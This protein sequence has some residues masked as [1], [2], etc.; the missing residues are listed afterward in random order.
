MYF[1]QGTKAQRHD[2]IYVPLGLL[3]EH[4]QTVHTFRSTAVESAALA[5]LVL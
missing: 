1:I 4:E 2:S 3:K 5:D